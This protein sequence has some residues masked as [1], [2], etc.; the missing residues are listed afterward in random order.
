[1][2]PMCNVDD[3]TSSNGISSDFLGGKSD[4]LTVEKHEGSQ[5]K[6]TH[7]ALTELNCVIK[8]VPNRVI[9]KLCC[10]LRK[11]VNL[12]TECLCNHLATLSVL[13]AAKGP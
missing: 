5:K 12:C 4:I 7:R 2:M 9:P 6:G 1:M 3:P 13:V 10:F 11:M 8:M